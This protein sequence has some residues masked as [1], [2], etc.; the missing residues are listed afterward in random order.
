M[1]GDLRGELPW[2][3]G[4]YA[5]LTGGMAAAWWLCRKGGRHPLRMALIAGLVF[6]LLAAWGDPMLSDDLYRFLWDGRVQEAGIHPF[7]HAPL[8]E[9]LAELR[10]DD[11]ARI[12]H[13][14]LRT[15]YPPLAEMFFLLLAFL[16]SGPTLLKLSVGLLDFGVCLLLLHMLDVRGFP[17]P[18]VVLYAWSP[19][20]ILET[21]GS[22]HIE[23]LGT[24]LVLVALTFLRREHGIAAGGALAG[25]VQAKLMPLIL[26][27]MVL[28]HRLRQVG[29]AGALQALGAFTLVFV[30][31]L[32]PYALTGPAVGSGLFAYGERWEHNA[33][34]Y[35]GL[36]GL[37]RE[38]DPSSLLKQLIGWLKST[39][40]GSFWDALYPYVW[41][42]EV[43]RILVAAAAGGLALLIAWKGRNPERQA[44]T[45]LGVVLL[46]SPTVHPWYVLWVLPLACL[47][48]SRGWLWLA[49]TVPVSYIG[50][51]TD[52]PWSIRWLQY[53]PALVLLAV[54][55]FES[56]L[57]R[58]GSPQRL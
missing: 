17:R 51:E 1:A 26:L 48:V 8:D 14:E 33:F 31:L 6:R 44:L 3:L 58:S 42:R 55:F 16:G 41:P 11:W 21:A 56:K 45:T 19:L 38:F 13:P 53:G 49:L 22:G 4:A 35:A 36:E 10:D 20:A 47:L 23:P 39:F 15:I 43:A 28:A 52:V 9:E 2:F 54:E 40:G 27:P 25:A 12:N 50:W 18:R 5:G 24:L 34:L 46:L 30:A 32:L 29:R 7:A 37:L 57:R